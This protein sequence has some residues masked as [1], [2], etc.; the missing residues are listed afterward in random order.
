MAIECK[1]ECE[2]GA[3]DAM[4]WTMVGDSDGDGNGGRVECKGEGEVGVCAAR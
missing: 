4:S 2:V 1:V 3:C